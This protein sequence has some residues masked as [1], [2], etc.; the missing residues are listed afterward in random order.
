[1]DTGGLAAHE[2]AHAARSGGLP[3]GAGAA[4]A[5]VP[6]RHGVLRNKEGGERRGGEG[7]GN[8]VSLFL[9]ELMVTEGRCGRSVQHAPESRVLLYS[10][11]SA[12]TSCIFS[13]LVV[14]M[15][16]SPPPP[17]PPH[18]PPSCSQALTLRYP[19]SPHSVFVCGSC[20][21]VASPAILPVHSPAHEPLPP[22]PSPPPLRS[23]SR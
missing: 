5:T 17:H 9:R 11:A 4:A 21:R 15:G 14:L 18:P 2:R 6:S 20:V 8:H 10:S 19:T 13:A 22:L 7:R 16:S 1:M 3:R 12:P 23:T